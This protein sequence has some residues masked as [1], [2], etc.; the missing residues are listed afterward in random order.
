ME[1]NP[2]KGSKLPK[3]KGNKQW[4]ISPPILSL[5]NAYNQFKDLFL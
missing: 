1:I 4:S 5:M 2:E 3:K